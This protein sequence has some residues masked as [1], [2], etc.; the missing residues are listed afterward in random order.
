MRT[1][2]GKARSN[3]FFGDLCP[4]TRKRSL[5]TIAAKFRQRENWVNLLPIKVCKNIL[6]KEKRKRKSHK[7]PYIFGAGRDRAMVCG[8]ATVGDDEDDDDEDGDD[9]GDDD[10]DDE[11]GDD[12][13][14]D[15]GGDADDGDDDN[16]QKG[17]MLVLGELCIIK[18]PPAQ[19][20][21]DIVCYTCSLIVMMML[22][23]ILILLVTLVLYLKINSA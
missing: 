16:G 20:G 4:S 8:I 3:V 1:G 14:D 23:V 18:L 9:V 10:D 5:K 6:Q 19:I 22:V 11:D 17:V 13:D 21:P 12:D 7:I 2:A 15:D